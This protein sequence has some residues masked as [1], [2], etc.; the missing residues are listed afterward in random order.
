MN[1]HK[2]R[3]WKKIYHLNLTY[4]LLFLPLPTLKIL[5]VSCGTRQWNRYFLQ[6]CVIIATAPMHWRHWIE[7][8]PIKKGQ[9][10]FFSFF[11]FFW[12]R[13][14]DFSWTTSL[15]H[16]SHFFYLMLKVWIEKN[17]VLEP[18][19]MSTTICKINHKPNGRLAVQR[20]E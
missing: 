16:V 4:H 20:L 2:P 15:T 6:P 3:N 12:I 13:S 5:N 9:E 18:W 17:E 7:A 14:K 10:F 8:T 19:L 1:T 11:F